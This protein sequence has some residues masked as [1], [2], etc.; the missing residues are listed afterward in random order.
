[1]PLPGLPAPEAII[2]LPP[3]EDEP[4][5][6]IAQPVKKPSAMKYIVLFLFL[7]AGGAGYYAYS[8]N[9]I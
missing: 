1:M 2:S 3:L 9:L 6:L 5:I 7:I 4:S 8:N